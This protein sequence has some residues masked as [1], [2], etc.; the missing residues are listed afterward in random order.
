MNGIIKQAQYADLRG[1]HPICAAVLLKPPAVPVKPKYART[2]LSSAVIPHIN[3]AYL[4]VL[5]NYPNC[6]HDGVLR[7]VEGLGKAML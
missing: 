2:V 6:V 4:H 3:A 7:G 1:R 5:N